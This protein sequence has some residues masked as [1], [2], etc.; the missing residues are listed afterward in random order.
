MTTL[1]LLKAVST[2]KTIVTLSFIFE[3]LL[4]VLFLTQGN[5]D[6]NKY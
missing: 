1:M 5:K 4:V 3:I 6:L 2:I